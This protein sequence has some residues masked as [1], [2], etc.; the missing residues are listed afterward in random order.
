MKRTNQK[1]NVYS[2]TQKEE[3]LKHLCISDLDGR[4]LLICYSFKDKIFA[5]IFNIDEKR[6][7]GKEQ[8]INPGEEL[9]NSIIKGLAVEKYKSFI[10]LGILTDKKIVIKSYKVE[11]TTDT[12][13]SDID[14]N[15]RW[16][17]LFQKEGSDIV[18]AN[19]EKM[20]F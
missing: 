10:W 8:E 17:I 20:V 9:D 7:I 5:K 19:I 14:V 18:E 11:L 3:D 4:N 13:G 6:V 16:H 15:F 2:I 12:S 1:L